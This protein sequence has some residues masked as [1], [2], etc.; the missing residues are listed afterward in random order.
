MCRS[1]A[2]LSTAMVSRSLTC[3]EPLA[4]RFYGATWIAQRRFLRVHV[5][6]PAVRIR[7]LAVDHVEKRALQRLGDR[8]AAAAPDLYPVDRANRRHLGGGADDE[9][10]VGDVQRLAGDV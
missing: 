3:I 1:D 10:F 9:H 2:P 7:H 8:P 5:G 4:P 6:Q